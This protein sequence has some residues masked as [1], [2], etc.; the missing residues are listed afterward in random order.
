MKDERTILEK[1]LAGEANLGD[2]NLD[3]DFDH[4]ELCE[5]MEAGIIGPDDLSQWRAS[6]MILDGSLSYDDY[7]FEKFTPYEQV[8]QLERGVIRREDFKAKAE[9]EYY[10]GEDWLQLLEVWPELAGEAPWDL[11][12]DAAGTGAGKETLHE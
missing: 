8:R 9:L 12:R 10:D 3:S 7:P 6:D 2:Y 11:I 4:G 1:F 5:L